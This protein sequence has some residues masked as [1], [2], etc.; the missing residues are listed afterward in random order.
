MEEKLWHTR[1]H[2][3]KQ[4][5]HFADK[6]TFFFSSHVWMW[7]LD[8]KE[9]WEYK[10]WCFQIVAL[11]KTLKNPL[12]NKVVKPVNPNIEVSPEYSLEELMLKL[13]TLTTWWKS[14]LTG[15]DPDAGKDWRQEE[16]GT[17][18]DEMVGW[19]H[20]INGHE[21]EQAQET[22]KDRENRRAIVHGVT[23]SGTWLSDRTQQVLWAEILAF[24]H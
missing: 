1:Q 2:T 6:A 4:R 22:L 24:V 12:D 11:E 21:F 19:H 15:K 10:N 8:R 20:W 16:K 7:E 3:K 9:G 13:S 23:K 14:Q 18:E 17:T 5:H